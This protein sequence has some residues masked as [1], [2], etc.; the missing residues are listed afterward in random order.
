V[1]AYICR[2]LQSFSLVF[3]GDGVLPELRRFL[4]FRSTVAQSMGSGCTSPE[5]FVVNENGALGL[6]NAPP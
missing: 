4:A 1:V 3:V 6:P 5:A 2:Y